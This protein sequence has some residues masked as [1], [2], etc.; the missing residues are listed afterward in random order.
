MDFD[1]PKD[2]LHPS[3]DFM[4]GRVGRLVKVDDTGA[5]VGLQVTAQ[6]GGTSGDRGE[7][8]GTDEHYGKL[9]MSASQEWRLGS[10]RFS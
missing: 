10:I 8:T 4:T 7:V 1:L 5:D 6:G 3:H 9:S 2:P